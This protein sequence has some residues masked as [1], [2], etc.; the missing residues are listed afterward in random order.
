MIARSM[1]LGGTRLATNLRVRFSSATAGNPLDFA[2]AIASSTRSAFGRGKAFFMRAKL[3]SIVV[4]VAVGE[5]AN[6]ALSVSKLSRVVLANRS[7]TQ[8]LPSTMNA[9]S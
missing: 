8:C 9:Y 7:A 3:P 4:V 1:S 6:T 2:P 5:D